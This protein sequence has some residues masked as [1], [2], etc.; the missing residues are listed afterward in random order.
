MVGRLKTAYKTE[1]DA[2]KAGQKFDNDDTATPKKRGRKAKVTDD[3]EG[4]PQTTPKRKSK[5]A[6]ADEDGGSPK[7]KGKKGAVEEVK[8]EANDEEVKAEANDESI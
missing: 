3:G 4:T 7:K 8:E 5:A 6:L 2:L 1:L